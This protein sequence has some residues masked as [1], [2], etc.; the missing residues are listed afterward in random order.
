MVDDTHYAKRQILSEPFVGQFDMI[1]N[2]IIESQSQPLPVYT[3]A[4]NRRKN[5]YNTP[6]AS[7]QKYKLHQSNYSYFPSSTA[8]QPVSERYTVPKNNGGNPVPASLG[9]IAALQLETAPTTPTL[10]PV[11]VSAP[12]AISGSLVGGFDPFQPAA[13]GPLFGSSGILG[14]L[15]SAPPITTGS[16]WGTSGTRVAS[17]AAVWG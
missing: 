10:R 8:V 16:I 11:P 5:T 2:T 4:Q 12:P 15:N 14:L 17:D 6:N 7:S 13:P 1:E 9:P 3:N